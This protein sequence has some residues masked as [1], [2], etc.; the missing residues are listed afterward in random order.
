MPSLGTCFPSEK[1]PEEGKV[2]DR[3]D[4]GKL[5]GGLEGDKEPEKRKRLWGLSG[6]EERK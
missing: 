2:K 4:K 3:E 1:L 5:A 6:K